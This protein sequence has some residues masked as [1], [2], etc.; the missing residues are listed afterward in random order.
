MK[1]ITDDLKERVS[2]LEIEIAEAQ[3]KLSSLTDRKIS[4]TSLIEVEESRWQRRQPSLLPESTPSLSLESKRLS[5]LSQF[6]LSSLKDGEKTLE[7][8]KE[9]VKVNN[10]P[11]KAVKPGRGIAV[12]LVKLSHRGLTEKDKK[13]GKWKLKNGKPGDMAG[14]KDLRVSAPPTQPV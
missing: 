1:N 2:E 12:A 7:E 10:I 3:R 4:L 11:I 9:K 6:L 13:D 5:P 14:L 8:L